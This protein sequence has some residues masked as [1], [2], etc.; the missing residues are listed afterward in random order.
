MSRR[1]PHPN[2]I[3]VDESIEVLQAY[4]LSVKIFNF[5]QLRMWTDETHDMWDWFHTTGSLCNY[6]SEGICHKVGVYKNSEDV[7]IK[8]NNYKNGK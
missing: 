1:N 6:N 4:G 2:R 8:I 3:N 7:A 5:Y